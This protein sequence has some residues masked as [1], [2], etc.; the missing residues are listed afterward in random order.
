M[1]QGGL[2]AWKL[3]GKW[4]IVGRL[5]VGDVVELCCSGGGLGV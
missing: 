5:L 2:L 4:L 3:C 1:R